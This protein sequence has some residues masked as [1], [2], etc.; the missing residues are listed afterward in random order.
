MNTREFLFFI[1][2]F[3]FILE[4]NQMAVKDVRFNLVFFLKLF[5]H[6]K[7]GRGG[8]YKNLTADRSLLQARLLC[9]DPV[10][11]ILKKHSLE[12]LKKN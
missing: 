4:K 3:F 7:R 10:P 8:M 12:T 1:L 6:K 9:L 2:F 11:N 5:S